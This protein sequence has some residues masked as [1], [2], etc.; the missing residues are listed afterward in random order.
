M[1]KVCSRVSRWVLKVSSNERRSLFIV[2]TDGSGSCVGWARRYGAE[3]VRLSM[4][5]MPVRMSRWRVN[6]AVNAKDRMEESV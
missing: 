6:R 1:M 2:S 4:W 5:I 3:R